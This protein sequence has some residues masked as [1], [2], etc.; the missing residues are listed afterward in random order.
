M[1]VRASVSSHVCTACLAC[2]RF[3]SGF[4]IFVGWQLSLRRRLL[5][6]QQTA[7]IAFGFYLPRKTGHKTLQMLNGCLQIPRLIAPGMGR[8]QQH[9][10]GLIGRVNS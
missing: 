4:V 9:C 8:C 10:A 6:L 2:S 5:A 3:G 1:E 7:E